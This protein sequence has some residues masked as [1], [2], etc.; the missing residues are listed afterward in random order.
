MIPCQEVVLIRKERSRDG[1]NC[2]D[3]FCRQNKRNN[4]EGPVFLHVPGVAD[5]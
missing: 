4:I 3:D 1:T 2:V 5:F